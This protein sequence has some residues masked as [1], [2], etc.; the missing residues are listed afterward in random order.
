MI[1]RF[2]LMRCRW[3][4]V[5]FVVASVSL[6]LSCI[7]LSMFKNR[8][9]TPKLY[10]GSSISKLIMWTIG[11]GLTGYTRSTDWSIDWLNSIYLYVVIGVMS[12]L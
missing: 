8:D 5:D 12:T 11:I 1:S 7:E 6:L 4:I 9:L 3:T 10:L 2:E